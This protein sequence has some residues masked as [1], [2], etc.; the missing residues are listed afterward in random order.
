LRARANA[1][2]KFW[3]PCTKSWIRPLAHL[4]LRSLKHIYISILRVCNQDTLYI[5]YV[6]SIALERI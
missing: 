1:R 2:A 3:T 5:S 4:H 6:V